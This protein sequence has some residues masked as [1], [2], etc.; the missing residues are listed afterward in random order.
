ME[1]FVLVVDT[2]SF[3]AAARRLNVGQPAVSK[4]VAQLEERLGI[5]SL[6]LQARRCLAA[7]KVHVRFHLQ[8]TANRIV[9]YY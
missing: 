6:V 3:S 4:M 7:L 8:S 2:G 9:D 5:R 1:E